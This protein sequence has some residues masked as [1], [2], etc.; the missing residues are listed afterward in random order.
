[1]NL[2]II[3]TFFIF[4]VP[5]EV[6]EANSEKLSQTNIELERLEIALGNLRL[7]E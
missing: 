2:F 5:L 4:K 3:P 7:M 1:M 6:Q